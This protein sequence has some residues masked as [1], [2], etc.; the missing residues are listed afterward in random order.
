MNLHQETL[1][2]NVLAVVV[3]E[4]LSLNYNHIHFLNIEIHLKINSVCLDI[5]YNLLSQEKIQNYKIVVI[6]ELLKLI[7]VI[8][9]NK[10][11]ER[12]CKII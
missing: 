2:I 7:E 3:V 10:K 5:L 9:I 11:E 12:H 6:M 4:I 1:I 8:L